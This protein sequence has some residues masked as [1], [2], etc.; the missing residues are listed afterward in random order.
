M[1]RAAIGSGVRTIVATSRWQAGQTEPPLPFKEIG[2][3]VERLQAE[4]KGALTIKSGFMFEFSTGLPELT[5]RYG[6]YVTLGGKRCL[7]ISLP[8]VGVPTE[9]FEVLT[10]LLRQ[11]FSVL[12]AHPECS[13]A[14]RR[15][16]AILNKWAS[17]GMKFQ[18]DAASV[19]G[20]YGREVK[21]FAIECLRRFDKISVIASNVRS[22]QANPLRQAHAELASQV[23]ERQATRVVRENPM[24]IVSDVKTHSN[25]KSE[26]ATGGL[27][28]LLRVLRPL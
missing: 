24:A 12:I 17:Q 9:S 5:Q 11:G 1:C 16:S 20:T 8:S 7:L 27:T 4:T 18:F 15:N 28:A 13:P 21:K 22:V 6:A 23:G 14:L 3:K 26:E 19:I 2:R 25:G 10:S